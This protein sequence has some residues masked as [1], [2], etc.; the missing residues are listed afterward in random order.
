MKEKLTHEGDPRVGVGGIAVDRER[1]DACVRA[2]LGCQCHA[3]VCKVHAFDQLSAPVHSGRRQGKTESMGSYHPREM[4][5]SSRVLDW[6]CPGL[7]TAGQSA[8]M[9]NRQ[10][11]SNSLCQPL[12]NKMEVEI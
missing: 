8:I 9:N 12:S 10:K 11:I 6:H 1:L 2:P 7:M 3:G 4:Q 5:T